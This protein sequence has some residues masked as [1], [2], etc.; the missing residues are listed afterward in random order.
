MIRRYSLALLVVTLLASSAMAT[1]GRQYLM[2]HSDYSKA[3]RWHNA[4]TQWHGGYAHPYWKQP[5][6]LIAPP[7]ANMQTSYSWGVGRTRMVPTYHQFTRPYVAPG[8]GVG[9]GSAA[10]NWPVSTGHQ[11]VYYIRGPW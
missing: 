10:P 5:V 9:T 7:N 8:G 1:K 2:M 4:N 3:A 11:G 6:A